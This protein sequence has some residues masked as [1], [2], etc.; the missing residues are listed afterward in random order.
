MSFR[1]GKSPHHYVTVQAVRCETS[2]AILILSD[3]ADTRAEFGLHVAYTTTPPSTTI[4]QRSLRIQL[5]IA[6]DTSDVP[7]GASRPAAVFGR[8]RTP[9]ILTI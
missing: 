3:V 5:H 7:V 8:M 6:G 2:V 4:I 1:G 9:D